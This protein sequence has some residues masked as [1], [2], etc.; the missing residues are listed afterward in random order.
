MSFCAVVSRMLP[1]QS[2]APAT[3]HAS[4][5]SERTYGASGCEKVGWQD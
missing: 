4:N 2:N 1:K 3:A 5:T